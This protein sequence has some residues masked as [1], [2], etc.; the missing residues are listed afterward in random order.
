MMQR[1][2]VLNAKREPATAWR[3]ITGQFQAMLRP[4]AVPHGDAHIP[5]PNF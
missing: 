1:M 5:E 3:S 4:G 2:G